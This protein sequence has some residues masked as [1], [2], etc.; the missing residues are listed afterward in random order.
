MPP[1]EKRYRLVDF[2]ALPGRECPCGIAHRALADV[3]EFPGT[4]HRT[5]I[6]RDAKLHYRRRLAETYCVL[7]C[8]P[9]AKMQ[10]DDDLLPVRPGFCV[11]IPPG[12]RHRAIGNLTVLIVCV[13]AFDPENEVVVDGA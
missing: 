3:P 10:L 7:E 4:Q 8:E 2:D 1:D 12:V 9:G 11:F 6:T 13:P 5:Q